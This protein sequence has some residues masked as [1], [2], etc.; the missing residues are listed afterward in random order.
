M[1]S[2]RNISKEKER[3]EIIMKKL[4][5]GTEINVKAIV[6]QQTDKCVHVLVGTKVIVLPLSEVQGVN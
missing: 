4:K 6:K 1:S 3:G 5:Q 2:A